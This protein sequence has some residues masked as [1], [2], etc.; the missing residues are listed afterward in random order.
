V[1]S[2]ARIDPGDAKALI[3]SGEA[4]V[5]DVR[6]P[7]EILAS[8]MV[9]GAINI[10]L[11]VFLAKTDPASSEREAALSPEKPVILYCA[12]GKRSEF[13]GNKLLE[14]GYREVFN[15]GGLRDWQL[16]GHPVDEPDISS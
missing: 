11:A 13:A 2:V 8:G 10:P 9:P 15:L 14:F 3:E 16:A 6:E 5:I 12:S 4:V 7:S 1:E